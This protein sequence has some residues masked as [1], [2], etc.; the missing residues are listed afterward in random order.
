MVDFRR[1]FNMSMQYFST[2]RPGQEKIH[3]DSCFVIY[4]F[5]R[6]QQFQI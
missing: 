1:F 5:D 3:L 6:K 2:D 4:Y